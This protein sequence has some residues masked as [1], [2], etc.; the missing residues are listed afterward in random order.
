MVW[1]RLDDHFDQNP[2]IAAVGPLGIALWVTGL[3]YCNRNLTDGFIPW[4]IAK[5][6][7]S[8]EYLE[9]PGDNGRRKVQS[10]SVSCGMVGD[11]VDAERVID[12]LLYAGLWDVDDDRGGYRIH[13]YEQFQ[14]SKEQ[15]LEDRRASADRTAKSRAK[16]HGSN[17]ASNTVGNSVSTPAPVPVPVPDPEP[18]TE[19]IAAAAAREE[20]EGADSSEGVARLCREW[21]RATGFTV[22]AMLGD[23]FEAALATFPEDWVT[24]AIR[25]TGQANGRSWKY[26]NTILQRWARDGRDVSREPID[27]TAKFRDQRLLKGATVVGLLGGEK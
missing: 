17:G 1:V 9:P 15:V 4:N 18:E 2:K 12:L 8:W 6:L 3:A 11:S 25:E 23:D 26:T 10:L 16:S 13:D 24:D 20:T 7:L 27:A 21:E 19:E 22:T 5:S 14:P